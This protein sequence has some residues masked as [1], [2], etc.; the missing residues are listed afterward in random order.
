YT[1]LA[2]VYF[3]Q[4]KLTAALENYRESNQINPFNPLIHK[5][6]GLIHYRL[7]EETKAEREWTIARRLLPGDIEVESWLLEIERKKP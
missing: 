5:Y 7:G 1:S 2:T 6:M 3:I 4:E